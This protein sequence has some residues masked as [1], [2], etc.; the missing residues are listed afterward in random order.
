M[1]DLIRIGTAS[2]VD[3]ENLTARVHFA[4]A[5]MVSGSLK[6]TQAL[7]E[8]AEPWLP[9]VGDLVLC[10]FPKNGGGDGFVV[11]RIV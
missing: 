1:K 7:P 3:A 10:L 5:G 9:G 8:D 11:G 2:S 4:D 6:I